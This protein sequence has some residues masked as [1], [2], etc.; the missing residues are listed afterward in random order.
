MAE[1]CVDPINGSSDH[2]GETWDLL[3]SGT[4]GRTYTG[5]PKF[6]SETGGFTGME[7]RW[8]RIIGTVYRIVEVVSDTEINVDRNTVTNS[9][10]RPFWIGGAVYTPYSIDGSGQRSPG[11]VYKIAKSPDPVSAGT[12]TYTLKDAQV[13]FGAGR[14]KRVDACTEGWVAAANVTASYQITLRPSGANT[15]RLAVAS[16]FTT[17]KL[18]YHDLGEGNE[19][20]LSA[21]QGVSLYLKIGNVAL[22]TGGVIQLCF[23]SDADGDV[24]VDTLEIQPLA[25]HK[26]AL[27]VV[28]YAL[29]MGGGNLGSSI[30]SIALY[31][32]SDPSTTY[33]HVA[34]IIAVKA[35]GDA[36]HICHSCLLSQAATG[37][38]WWSILY[39]DSDS[40]LQLTGQFYGGQSGDVATFRRH[41]ALW[42]RNV[43]SYGSSPGLPGDP[44]IFQGGYDP[45]TDT[46][47]G[48]TAAQLWSASSDT[49]L[50][51]CISWCTAR[52]FIFHGMI[53]GAGYADGVAFE[54][55]DFA[56]H[57]CIGNKDIITWGSLS[58][59][60]QTCEYWSFR[61]I[62]A[63]GYPAPGAYFFKTPTPSPY[64]LHSGLC[65]GW[66]WED[67]RVL[68][69]GS[70]YT[71][72]IS[73]W[74]MRNVEISNSPYP[75]Q[76]LLIGNGTHDSEFYNLTLNDNAGYGLRCDSLA[77]GLRFWN[78]TAKGNALGWL[79]Y[80]HGELQFY[81]PDVDGDAVPQGATCSYRHHLMRRGG[82]PTDNLI[83][84]DLGNIASDVNTRHTA[85]GIS[86]KLS[87][88]TTLPLQL[89]IGTIAVEAGVATTI[90]LWMRR[91]DLNIDG[92][93]FVRGGQVVGVP[94]DLE[95]VISAA[96]DMWELRTIELTATASGYIEVWAEAWGDAEH[97]VYVDDLSVVV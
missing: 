97:S 8:I 32:T 89:K 5:S 92:R 80:P 37:E 25:L 20:D 70:L 68:S 4:D 94:N 78:L 31:A 41:G 95:S 17:G 13:G 33:V 58:T 71:R 82:N 66:Y 96:A 73:R 35:I 81:S 56:A 74:V 85:S 27:G 69:C 87:P 61:R 3:L 51:K 19:L 84:S 65:P 79:N 30:R 46:K 77:S 28:S 44:V 18:A 14:V 15:L 21:F 6:T 76:G 52:D 24:V 49:S 7:G 36:G 88:A 22:A 38:P 48:K 47:N 26:D 59:A 40:T 11:D 55:V 34:D 60:W 91:S 57:Y 67:V 12:L 90:G 75:T 62:T 93:L 39:F 2:T 50:Y 23:C 53:E 42:T 29:R 43:M 72:G 16:A 83:Q 9:T 1:W 63:T 45:A 64:D 54:D 86:W 10:G